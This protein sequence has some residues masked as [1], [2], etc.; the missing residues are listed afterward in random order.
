M[1]L[2]LLTQSIMHGD[3]TAAQ[4]LTWDLLEAGTPPAQILDALT[5]GMDDVGRRF[6][7]DEIFV[8][9]VLIASRAMKQAMALLEPA[10]T[11]SGHKPICNV[12]IG[13]VAGD[14]HDIG[15][16]LV[17]MMWKGANVGVIDLGTNVQPQTFV[18]AAIEHD[19]KIVGVSAL[20]TTTMINMGAVGEAL[21]NAGLSTV[22]LV[23]GG[24][25]VTQQFADE[26]GAHGYAADAASAVDML[27]GFTIA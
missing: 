22:K 3:R 26:I 27:K 1:S 4:D 6:K 18:E 10:L 7:A 14:M 5:T 19:A 17:T 21:R 23:I 11:E 24:A 13:T 25:P 2:N 15:K 16:N 8:P 9:E 20:L 12:V